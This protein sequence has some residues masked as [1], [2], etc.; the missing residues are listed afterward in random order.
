M[1][2]EPPKPKSV[3]A[4]LDEKRA[5]AAEPELEKRLLEW[6]EG[7]IGRKLQGSTF[8]E[9]VMDC[10]CLCDLINVISPGLIK[11]VHRSA[12]VMFR[13]ENFGFFC[14][15]SLELGV[16]SAETAIFEDLY[17]ERRM[18]QF[19]IHLLAVARN[20]QY[21]PGYAGPILA[22]AV[23]PS[24]STKQTF[25]PEQLARTAEQPTAADAAANIAGKAMQD[26]RYVEHGIIQNPQDHKYHGH[27]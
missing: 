9:C 10:A 16:K 5:P 20:S 14:T 2:A 22:D 8:R 25:T 11:K 21:R 27:K 18:S 12:I 19:L 24:E 17:E 4:A 23:R 15:A 26:S 1:T 13:R 6:I 7:N 3:W